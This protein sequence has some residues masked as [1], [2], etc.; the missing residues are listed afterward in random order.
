MK[1][2]LIRHLW[3]VELPWDVAFAKFKSEVEQAQS[4]PAGTHGVRR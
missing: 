4:S 2:K 3:G 1:L